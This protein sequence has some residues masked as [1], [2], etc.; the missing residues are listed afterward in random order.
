MSIMHDNNM[1]NNTLSYYFEEPDVQ[2]CSSSA[3]PPLLLHGKRPSW[4]PEAL[5]VCDADDLIYEWYAA[6]D[7]DD[8]VGIETGVDAKGRFA[9]HFAER[10]LEGWKMSSYVSKVNTS[11]QVPVTTS[12]VIHVRNLSRESPCRDIVSMKGRL[13][14]SLSG[15]E[16]QWAWR[17]RQCHLIL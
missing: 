17:W 11:V 4:N 12:K 16:R 5:E 2:M 10:F 1:H 13:R 3:P 8:L 14:R 6:W 9:A 15:S 7:L